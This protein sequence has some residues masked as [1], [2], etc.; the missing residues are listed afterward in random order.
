MLSR[1]I[2]LLVVVLIAS[3]VSIV[4]QQKDD[5]PSAEVLTLED[6]ISLALHD[7]RQVK[8]AQL[9]I[10][11]AGDEVAAARTH[12]LPSLYAYSVV[13]QQ[14]IKHDP[15]AN[16][17]EANVVPGVGPFFSIGT[18]REPTAIFAGQILQPLTQ[19]HR[20]HLEIRQAGLA[21]EVESEKL[22]QA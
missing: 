21:R 9:S 19:L 7:N 10:G 8:N 12:R 6:A 15:G 13:S 17:S 14:F 22:R 11:K 18:T 4:A 1:V 16:S 2:Y 20:I 3:Q 5:A